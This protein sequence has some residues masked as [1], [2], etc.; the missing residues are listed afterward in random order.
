[1]SV[2]R[3]SPAALLPD[4]M[5]AGSGLAVTVVPLLFTSP[6]SVMVYVLAGLAALFLAFGVRVVLKQLTRIEVTP[7]GVGAFGPLGGNIAWEDLRN[8]SIRY[9]STRRDRSQ[10]WMQLTIVGQQGRIRADSSISGFSDLARTALRQAD[11]LGVAVSEGTRANAAA[12]A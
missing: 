8:V 9:F 10:G 2:H 5:R 11:R 7:A 6:S 12:L 3:Y 4:Y 1:M